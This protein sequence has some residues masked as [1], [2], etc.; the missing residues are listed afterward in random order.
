MNTLG[1]PHLR[2]RCFNGLNKKIMSCPNNKLLRICDF[3]CVSQ[4]F[5]NFFTSK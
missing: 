4:Q 2:H 5:F 3:K 1:I